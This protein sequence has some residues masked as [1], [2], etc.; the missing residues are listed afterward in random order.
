MVADGRWNYVFCHPV[1]CIFLRGGKWLFFNGQYQ[2][3]NFSFCDCGCVCEPELRCVT[4]WV[5]EVPS[6]GVT[7]SECDPAEGRSVLCCTRQN[8]SLESI[9][10]APS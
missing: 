2:F 6:V 1:V 10:S 8:S 3:N 9:S 4:L 7:M 5:K